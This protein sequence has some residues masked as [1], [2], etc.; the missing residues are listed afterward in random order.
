MKLKLKCLLI[1]V[2]GTA[3]LATIL[4][5]AIFLIKHFKYRHMI[6]KLCKKLDNKTNNPLSNN[7]LVLLRTV[8]DKRYDT[9]TTYHFAQLINKLSGIM[10]V[11]YSILGLLSFSLFESEKDSQVVTSL[12][13]IFFVVFALYISPASKAEQYWKAWQKYD[14]LVNKMVLLCSEN[15]SANELAEANEYC[16][17]TI[18]E[19]EN[20]LS[21]DLS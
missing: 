3:V 6:R 14:C 4:Y 9:I 7:F 2:T 18:R 13:S 1:A 5:L 19:V 12:L 17:K 10:S 16:L 21:S 8:A 20:S 15:V 11:I